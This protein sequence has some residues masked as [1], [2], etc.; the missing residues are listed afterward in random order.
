VSGRMHAWAQNRNHTWKRVI[1]DTVG[2]PISG[3]IAIP[4]L[5]G[6]VYTITWWNPYSVTQAIFLTQTISVQ[7]TTTV[8][9]YLPAPLQ[10]D[11]AFK[12]E[13][14][15]QWPPGAI[16]RAFVPLVARDDW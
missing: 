15:W 4:N 5:P 16:P 11:V 10:A 2:A 1:S 14:M 7:A 12:L 13:R 8:T 6:G 3:S 9:L